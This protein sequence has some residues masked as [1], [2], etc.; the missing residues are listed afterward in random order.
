MDFVKNSKEKGLVYALKEDF[1]NS[2]LLKVIIPFLLATNLYALSPESTE[3]Y[4]NGKIKK[5]FYYEKNTCVTEVYDQNGNMI[6]KIFDE[7]CN[8]PSQSDCCE[9]CNYIYN[10]KEMLECTE[11]EGCDGKKVKKFYKENRWLERYR[12][13]L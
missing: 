4:P 7:W 10:K 2:K 12:V 13:E 3:Y 9:K 11:D 1:Q 6:E 5:R 8:G